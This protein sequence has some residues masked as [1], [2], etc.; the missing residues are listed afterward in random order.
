MYAKHSKG[1]FIC[2]EVQIDK[3]QQQITLTT[4]ADH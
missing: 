2:I 4:K 1:G 3:T